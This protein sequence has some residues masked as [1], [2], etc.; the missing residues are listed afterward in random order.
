MLASTNEKMFA[1]V[2]FMPKDQSCP[3]EF[4]DSK[5]TFRGYNIQ[6]KPQHDG[7]AAIAATSLGRINGSERQEVRL[8]ILCIAETHTRTCSL[9]FHF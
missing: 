8:L 9:G 2:F 5:K 3:G 7:V 1:N 4:L 6:A